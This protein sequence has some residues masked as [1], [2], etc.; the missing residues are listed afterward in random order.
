M[1]SSNPPHQ[2]AAGSGSELAAERRVDGGAELTSDPTDAERL[3]PQDVADAAERLAGRVV[4]TPAIRCRALEAY[5]GAELWLKLESLQHVGAFKARGAMHAVGRLDP[6]RRADGIL[7]Y[8]SGNHAQAVA[9]AGREFAVPTT[10]VMPTDA[11]AIKVAGVRALGA[12]VEFAGT[13]SVHRRDRAHELQAQRGGVIIPPF[14]HADIITGQGT[15]TRELCE[16][17]EAATG[18]LPDLLLVPVGGGGVLAGA[19]LATVG[20]PVRVCSVEPRACDAMARSLE[21]GERVAVEPGET[22]ADGLKPVMVG[23]LNF[24]IATRY[25]RAWYRADEDEIALALARL[26]IRGKVVVE[27]SAAAA[28]AVALRGAKAL[29]RDGEAP[30]RI[31]VMVTG[32][33][34]E[35]RQLAGLIDRHAAHV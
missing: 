14:D 32:G 11:P 20:T 27:P 19:C 8:S 26:A 2:R 1:A 5:V 9:L 15:A 6:R 4:Q 30:R 23:A 3:G 7:T 12:Q 33:N 31:A 29:V 18:R 28:V 13:T 10:V 35:P 24:A 22:I 34:I 25:V 17:V 21:A 16:Q